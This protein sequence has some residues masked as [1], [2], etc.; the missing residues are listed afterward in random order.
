MSFGFYTQVFMAF[1]LFVQSAVH[2]KWQNKQHISIEFF[3]YGV[4]SPK[5]VV[6]LLNLFVTLASSHPQTSAM[7]AKE[8]SEIYVCTEIPI[9][10][11]T[12]F[13]YY[14]GHKSWYAIIYILNQQLNM[15]CSY[16]LGY[17]NINSLRHWNSLQGETLT[18]IF[19]KEIF[20]FGKQNI[21]IMK[22]LF[23]RCLAAK[24]LGFFSYSWSNLKMFDL[25]QT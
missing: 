12:V 7:S 5:L 1:N 21:Y 17:K 10:S 22:L 3:S 4:S 2:L 20:Y 24:L 11:R 16:S 13:F 15:C 25:E 23:M 8:C 9:R 14:A 6:L 19:R 18:T